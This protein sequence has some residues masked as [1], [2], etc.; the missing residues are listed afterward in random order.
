MVRP[1]VLK[2]FLRAR[3]HRW[4]LMKTLLNERDQRPRKAFRN[5][6]TLIFNNPENYC[7]VRY[8]RLRSKTP[9]LIAC[10]SIPD[11]SIWRASRQQPIRA[12]R[13]PTLSMRL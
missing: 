9:V 13:C 7:V 4:I 11:I 1:L 2:Q 10:H 12:T 6:G 3:P 5:R 8:Q